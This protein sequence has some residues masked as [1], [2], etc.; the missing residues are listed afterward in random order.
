M[1]RV[2]RA[3]K[4]YKTLPFYCG[5]Q[6]KPDGN[7]T[8]PVCLPFT[9]GICESTGCVVQVPDDLVVEA[10]EK[11]YQQEGLFLTTPL[12]E[13]VL[14]QWRAN[15]FLS[16]LTD[17]AG[18]DVRGKRLLEVGCS[19]GFLLNELRGRSA[20]V[21]GCEP[22]PSAL[23][24]RRK[25]GLDIEQCY[26]DANH[27]EPEYDFVIHLTVLEHAADPLAFLAETRKVLIE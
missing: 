7:G 8:L 22:G 1:E 11:A 27:F 19:T 12:D 16:V 3:I 25:Y 21:Q 24:A 18:L 15:E 14:H 10:L 26:F 17:T 23:A 13:S 4:K 6:N 2:L 5:V 9:L 20:R